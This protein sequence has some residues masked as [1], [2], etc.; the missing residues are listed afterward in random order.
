MV[1]LAV[2]LAAMLLQRLEAA[3]LTAPAPA[4][5]PAAAHPP[6]RADGAAPAFAPVPKPDPRSRRRRS[7]SAARATA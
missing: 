6:H 5:H 4:E 3:L 1:P 7:P 2:L